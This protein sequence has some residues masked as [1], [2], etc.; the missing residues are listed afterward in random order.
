[1]TRGARAGLAARR[2]ARRRAA[3]GGAWLRELRVGFGASG[4]V[5][6]FEI[7]SAN[8]VTVLALRHQREDDYR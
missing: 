4:Y 3:G 7:E 5:A 1:M 8:I 6:L 2:L